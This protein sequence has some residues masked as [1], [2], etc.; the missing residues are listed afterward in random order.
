VVLSDM[1]KYNGFASCTS[2]FSFLQLNQ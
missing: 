1:H 2:V